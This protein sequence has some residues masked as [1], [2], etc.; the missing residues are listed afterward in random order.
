MFGGLCDTGKA[1]EDQDAEFPGFDYSRCT[2]EV[3]IKK[4]IYAYK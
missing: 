3:N 4:G 1:P 2:P